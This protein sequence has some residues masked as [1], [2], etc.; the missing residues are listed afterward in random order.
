MALKICSLKYI[1]QCYIYIPRY[2]LVPEV[3]MVTLLDRW[4]NSLSKEVIKS[5]MRNKPGKVMFANDVGNFGN[6]TFN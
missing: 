2:V 1:E 6:T 5:F 4:T 3:L